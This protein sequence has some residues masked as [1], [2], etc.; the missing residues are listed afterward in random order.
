M[1]NERL[2]IRTFCN[3]HWQ[4][5]NLVEMEADLLGTDMPF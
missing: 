5:E 4:I 3:L 2:T 1:S